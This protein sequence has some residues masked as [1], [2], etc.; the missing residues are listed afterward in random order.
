MATPVLKVE[1]PPSVKV[2]L[3]DSP[4]KRR[5]VVSL[6]L[7]VLGLAVYNPATRMGFV[8]FDDPG[9]ITSNRNVQA[10]LS[11]ETVKWAFSTTEQANWHPLTWMS[12]ALDCQLFHLRAA[13][14]HYDNVLL[15][16]A[17][18]VLLFLFLEW[19]TGRVGTSA[20]VASLFAVHPINI[21]S[22]A[23]ISERKNVLCTLFFLLGLYAYA[24]YSR[25]PGWK[26]Y[27]AVLSSFALALMS[28][29]MAVTFP[30][31]L[32]LL[33]YWPLQ[34]MRPLYSDKTNSLSPE[35]GRSL[36][37]L[38]LE[39]IPLLAL[40]VASAVITVLA[41]KAG[42]A[43]RE[44]YGLTL[45]VENAIISYARYLGK[46]FW[47][48]HLAV[49][50]PF[51]R[52]GVPVWQTLVATAILFSI[53]AAVLLARKHYL[54]AGWLWFLGTLVPVIGL[55]QVGEQAMADRYAYIPF[56]GLFIAVV[57][58]VAELLGPLRKGSLYL[59]AMAV[60]TTGV[61]AVVAQAQMKYWES[62]T[63]LWS[64]AL[65]VT[66][67]N[68][69]AEDNLGAELIKEGDI[70]GARAH[71]QAAININA[72]DPFSQLNIG[73][74]DK[75][76]GNAQSAAQHYQAALKLSL[77]P[78]LRLTAFSNLGSLYRMSHDYEAA[79]TNY[80][81]ALR[82]N[83]DSAMPLIGMG[84][85]AQKTGDA[86][87]AAN[88]YSRG[89]AREPSDVGYVLL[90]RALEAAGRKPESASALEQAQKL[91]SDFGAAQNEA[92]RLLNE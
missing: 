91:A 82:I 7:A 63:A 72:E 50:Y 83:P 52:N 60:F 70:S 59:G 15:H 13:G 74:C 79:R 11:W 76:L 29:P 81:A 42:G 34:R 38:I 30:C 56:V 4:E 77:E 28:K 58:G 66:G 31:V 69:V 21:E 87:G 90:A 8:N 55:V 33:D 80:A 39:K 78:N 9:Y 45:R 86:A 44:Q 14:H 89:L 71:F 67:A 17:C 73:V 46:A 49:M 12:H 23:W 88:Y 27:T 20:S 1:A 26:R 64:H 24:W 37:S 2:A 62:T 18:V 43:M 32:L 3:F 61:L 84:L 19:T 92:T 65:Q 22:V 85:I 51:P 75:K 47:P 53:S 41:Q 10:G 25:K 57:W 68:F 5:F 35:R 16:V 48:S 6:L 54:T 36:W 40:S